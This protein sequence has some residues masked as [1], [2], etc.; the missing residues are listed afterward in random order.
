MARR[1][2]RRLVRSLVAEDSTNGLRV[3]LP[4]TSHRV[5]G[6]EVGDV[7]RAL[8]DFPFSFRTGSL[9]TPWPRKLSQ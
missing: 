3:R 7:A 4:Q 9:Y 6:E 5:F 8:T 1:G 2:L